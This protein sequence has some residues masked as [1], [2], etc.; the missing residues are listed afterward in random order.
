MKTPPVTKAKAPSASTAAAAPA[1]PGAI[2]A[3]FSSTTN[4]IATA[5][6]A[7]IV[8][9][10]GAAL[11]PVKNQVE[12]K[13]WPEKLRVEQVVTASED[14]FTPFKVALT[15]LS[16]G[17]GISGG[18][19]TLTP[20]DDSITLQGPLSFTFA[21]APGSSDVSP[22][23]GLAVRTRTLGESRIAVEVITN[24]GKTFKGRI[25]VRS[26][27]ARPLTSAANL[28]G[29][30]RFAIN[31]RE[32]DID[33]VEAKYRFTATGQ[34]DDGTRVS[35]KGWRDGSTF[36]LTLAAQDGRTYSTEGI[37]CTLGKDEPRFEVVNSRVT[38]TLNGVAVKDPV[39]LKYIGQR[40]ADFASLTDY[41]GDGVFWAVVPLG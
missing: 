12:R 22:T 41:D 30:W 24:K 5:L 13:V 33:L 34:F 27:Q 32:G 39:P 31:R 28:T 20:S 16:G 2:R 29:H 9:V 7:V 36:R 14:R 15:D 21:A 25:I 8:G 35:G 40:C 18:R 38:T 17:I 4:Q 10:V 11:A 6:V 19:I 37:Y 3:F 23:E 26:V 1:A